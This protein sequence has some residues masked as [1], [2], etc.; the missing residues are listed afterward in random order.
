VGGT[1]KASFS[2]DEVDV[3]NGANFDVQ[4]ILADAVALNEAM[5][6]VSFDAATLKFVSAVAGGLAAGAEP[7][8]GHRPTEGVLVLKNNSPVTGSGPLF[9]L[10][11]QALKPGDS[12]VTI[13]SFKATTAQAQ[14]LPVKVEGLDVSIE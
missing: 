6:T 12:T 7:A 11:F 8:L 4:L 1:A 2:P 10:T 3:A 5:V 14:S 13:A 9:K